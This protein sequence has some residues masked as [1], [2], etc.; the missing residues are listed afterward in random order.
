MLD[1]EMESETKL[2][3]IFENGENVSFLAATPVATAFF[4]K[5]ESPPLGTSISTPCPHF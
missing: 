5:M 3:H 4:S 1:F 2:R